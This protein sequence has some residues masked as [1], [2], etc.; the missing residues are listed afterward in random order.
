MAAGLFA[1]VSLCVCH[2]LSAPVAANSR[3][4]FAVRPVA[5]GA[6]VIRIG[7]V[8]TN[9]GCAV[10]L[11]AFRLDSRCAVVALAGTDQARTAKLA[12]ASGV[13]EA[14]GDWR[15][16]VG[17]SGIDAVAIATPPGMQPAI[18]IAALESG[19]PVFAEKPMAADLD[20]AGAMLRS[21]GTFR[22]TGTWR[23]RQRGCG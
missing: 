20:G 7:I 22:L 8:G 6:F 14:F 13:P 19:K 21:A 23:T 3:L 17:H 5:T 12:Q 2:D 1:V 18:A 10:Q 15:A 9:Y 11:P 4:E 16:L